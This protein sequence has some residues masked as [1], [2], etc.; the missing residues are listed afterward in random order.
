MCFFTHA[1]DWIQIAGLEPKSFNV[2]EQYVGYPF[3]CVDQGEEYCFRDVSFNRKGGCYLLS[4]EHRPWL[5]KRFRVTEAVRVYQY[6][7]SLTPPYHTISMYKQPVPRTCPVTA[8]MA[9]ARQR[10]MKVDWCALFCRLPSD[11]RRSFD[12]NSK[13]AQRYQTLLTTSR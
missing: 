11:S 3:I 12:R 7:F 10:L 6:L 1:P 8:N 2:A 4:D 5:Y 9:T 13:K